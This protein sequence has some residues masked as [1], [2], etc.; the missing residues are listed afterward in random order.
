MAK[1]SSSTSAVAMGSEVV[2]PKDIAEG[3]IEFLEEKGLSRNLTFKSL[4]EA[5]DHKAF[6][7]NANLYALM[8]TTGLY[9]EEFSTFEEYF[10][11]RTAHY[12][13]GTRLKRMAT[14]VGGLLQLGVKPSMIPTKEYPVRSLAA[15]SSDP[16]E[17]AEI[18]EAAHEISDGRTPTAKEIKEAAKV[19]AAKKTE[20]KTKK[21]PKHL[22]E[23]IALTESTGK[24]IL[25]RMQRCKLDAVE[26]SRTNAGSWM[27][28]QEVERDFDTLIRDVGLR[29]FASNCPKCKNNLTNHCDKCAGR[30]WIDRRHYTQLTEEQKRWLENQETT[31]S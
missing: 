24:D 5:I 31:E 27:N 7:D 18:I 6:C 28:S 8:K 26:F 25:A 3:V 12:S 16:Q 4:D 20:E 17:Q 29:M 19:V 14:I 1:K 11:D 22:I 23:V 15:A 21:T 2:L 9:K 30:G 13:Y 10:S